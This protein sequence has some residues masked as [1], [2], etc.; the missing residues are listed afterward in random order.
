MIK[1]RFA[2]K[3]AIFRKSP[4]RN[5]PYFF[6]PAAI[7]SALPLTNIVPL[8]FFTWLPIVPV[9]FF[10]FPNIYTVRYAYNAAR[11]NARSNVRRCDRTFSFSSSKLTR[12]TRRNLCPVDYR[13]VAAHDLINVRNAWRIHNRAEKLSSEK[14]I[15]SKNNGTIIIHFPFSKRI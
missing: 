15:L 3:D 11:R 6:Y 10:A 5:R 1:Y 13:L 4:N 7:P 2:I 14:G 9:P 12:G 8:A